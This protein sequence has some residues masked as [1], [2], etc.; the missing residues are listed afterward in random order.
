MARHEGDFRAV[1]EAELDASEL[2]MLG[3]AEAGR[4]AA[5]ALFLA[6]AEGWSEAVKTLGGAFASEPGLKEP[7]DD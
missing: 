5:L 2:R 4:E 3:L 7:K 6:G 1:A